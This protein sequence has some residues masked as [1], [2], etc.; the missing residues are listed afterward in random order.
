MVYKGI[1]FTTWSTS[2]QCWH[3][4]RI[5]HAS[6]PRSVEAVFCSEV[7][8]IGAAQPFPS[9]SLHCFIS[10]TGAFFF[11]FRMGA[12]DHGWFA[13]MCQPWEWSPSKTGISRGFN[14]FVVC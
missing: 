5:Q 6:G 11:P 10:V 9:L 12:H 3:V 7:L 8:S 4:S 1:F 2:D 14:H 13:M